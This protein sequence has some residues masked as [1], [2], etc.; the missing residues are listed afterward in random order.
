MSWEYSHLS[1]ER[2]FVSSVCFLKLSASVVDGSSQ[3][4][5]HVDIMEKVQKKESLQ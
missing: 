1:D 5:L 2:R 4:G 3:D